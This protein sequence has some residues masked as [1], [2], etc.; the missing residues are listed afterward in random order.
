MNILP[1]KL[2]KLKLKKLKNDI[3][4]DGFSFIEILIIIVIM[5]GIAAIVG[6]AL[7]GRL[8]EAKVDTAKI[9]MKSIAAALDQYH[10]D[11]NTYP[12]TEQGLEAII[13]RPEVGKIPNNWNGPY[14][15]G[16]KVPSD[17]WKNDY[18]YQSDGDTITLG[19]FGSDGEEGG[20]GS[21]ADITHE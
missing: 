11:N 20:D 17:P 12:D 14:L 5:A 19:S 3:A 10:L 8:D 18:F 7:F 13:S 6:P 16:K 4:Q 2:L 9:Q 1:K 21:K 15:K